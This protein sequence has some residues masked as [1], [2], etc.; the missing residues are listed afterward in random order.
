MFEEFCRAG[1]LQPHILRRIQRR[2]R[3]EIQPML[4]EREALIEENAKLREQI[5]ALMRDPAKR[6]PGR[7]RK[8][9][10]AVSA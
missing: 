5:A 3:D 9:A 6:G 10:E 7:P 1:S 8:D 2:V 4:D